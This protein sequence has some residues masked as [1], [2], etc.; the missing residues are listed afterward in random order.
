VRPLP[1]WGVKSQQRK[2]LSIGDKEKAKTERPWALFQETPT[3]KARLSYKQALR[4]W[5]GFVELRMPTTLINN[6]HHKENF[7]NGW[8]VTK[9]APRGRSA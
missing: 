6:K 1:S 3:G 5:S 2:Y 8:N 7:K 4:L 9:V